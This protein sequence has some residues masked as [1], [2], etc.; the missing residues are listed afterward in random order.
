MLPYLALAGSFLQQDKAQDEARRMAAANVTNP[1]LSEPQQ[2]APGP[3]QPSGSQGVGDKPYSTKVG[4]DAFTPNSYSLQGMGQ[5]PTGGGAAMNIGQGLGRPYTAETHPVAM[6]AGAPSAPAYGDPG[7]PRSALPD[8]R[9]GGAFTPA[10]GGPGAMQGAAPTA[11]A[12]TA[13]SAKGADDTGSVVAP[14][15]AAIGQHIGAQRERRELAREGRQ[16]IASQRAAEMG[17]PSYGIQGAATGRAMREVEGPDYLG[18]L[19]QMYRGG[20]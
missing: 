5:D 15:L 19:L 2:P 13:A 1:A 20:K 16:Q 4:S 6:E 17:Y 12:A 14:M 18:Q 7:R 8:Q 11:Q 10:Q 3:R 9:P